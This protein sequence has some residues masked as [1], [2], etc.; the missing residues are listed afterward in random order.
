MGPWRRSPSQARDWSLEDRTP[1][2]LRRVASGS[3]IKLRGKSNGAERPRWRRDPDIVSTGWEG[4]QDVVDAWVNR[5][6][7]ECRRVSGEQATGLFEQ[8]DLGRLAPPCISGD[9]ANLGGRRERAPNASDDATR[10]TGPELDRVRTWPGRHDGLAR[11]PLGD[12][13]VKR[14]DHEGQRH[15]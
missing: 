7:R 9:E 15:R 13:L 1:L 14:S 11:V 2:R 6:D 5:I 4:R 12:V 8:S 3:D 10:P